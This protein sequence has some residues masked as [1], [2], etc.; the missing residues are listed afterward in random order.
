MA[1]NALPTAQW[2]AALGVAE[3]RKPQVEAIMAAL[4]GQDSLVLL[5]TGAGKSL[6]F[7]ALPRVS[8]TPGLVV[9]V[10]PLLSLQEDQV[11][12]LVARGYRARAISSARSPAENKDTLSKLQEAARHGDD[13]E[14]PVELLY[15][16]PEALVTNKLLTVCAGLARRGRLLLVAVDEAHCISQW[17]HDFRSA[18]LRLGGALRGSLPDTVP[19]MAL[20]ATATPRVAA[21]IRASLRLRTDLAV[22]RGSMNRPEIKYEVVLVDGL[23]DHDSAQ[24]HLGRLL[25]SKELAGKCG[26]VYCATREQ[27]EHLAS[28]L[29]K[30]KIRACAYHAGLSTAT[31]KS[32]QAGWLGGTATDVMCATVAFGMGVDKADVRFVIHWALPQSF[33]AY[34]QESGRAARDGRPARSVVYYCDKDAS[35]ARFLIGKV[36][37]AGKGPDQAGDGGSGGGNAGG[38]SDGDASSESVDRKL[39]ALQRVVDYCI[40]PAGCRRRRLLAHFGEEVPPGCGGARCCDAC[41]APTEVKAAVARMALNQEKEATR[42][43]AGHETREL[44]EERR[45]AMGAR[46][47]VHGDRH[48]TGL[49]D[50]DDSDDE[51]AHRSAEGNGVGRAGPSMGHGGGG[52]GGEGVFVPVLPARSHGRVASK[53]KRAPQQQQQQLR[54][55]L[56]RLERREADDDER[57][58]SAGMSA[59]QKLK[60][61]LGM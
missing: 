35:T 55:K 15:C 1:A 14:M 42:R 2:A 7:Q 53:A 57:E 23:A 32:A 49:I 11:A 45:A 22:V 36:N 50:G 51:A 24:A 25:M 38:G 60:A 10:S 6:C 39:A 54:S 12:K 58:Q 43:R 46:K 40:A 41:A 19:L 61:R 26:V 21:D 18:Y 48:D 5:P 20:T 47:R 28:V 17:G 31:R 16:S 3:L 44:E 9:V 27:T 33:E 37:K 34:V 52:G 29:Q 30:A 56:S 8:R 13:V 59:A 4:S